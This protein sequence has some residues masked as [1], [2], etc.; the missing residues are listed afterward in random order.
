MNIYEREVENFRKLNRI[1]K[2]NSVVL[3]GSTFAKD[4]PVS[5]LVQTFDIDC[6]VYNRSLTDLSVFDAE[7]AA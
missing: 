5:E 3:L 7:K 4:I 6:N 2:K 1:A